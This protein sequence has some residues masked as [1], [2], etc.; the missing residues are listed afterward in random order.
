MRIGARSVTVGA[1]IALVLCVP[2]AISV[3][4]NAGNSVLIT[5][6]RPAIA[7]STTG[8]QGA[9]EATDNAGDTRWE[10][11]TGPGTQWLRVDL[12]AVR[13]I[14]RVRLRWAR[15][16][17]KTYRVQTS[18]DGANWV[19]VYATRSGNGGTDDL[20]RLGGTGRYLRVLATQR[21]RADGGTRC[22]ISRRTV[23]RRP[24]W[25]RPR[26]PPVR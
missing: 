1:G 8:V 10:S 3:A 11:A 22:G 25:P 5:R 15:A 12:G 7:S 14:D 26:R 17:A 18:S 2:L 24:P 4:A 6:N 13:R 9:T 21:A 16:Y 23:R 20:K 19:D